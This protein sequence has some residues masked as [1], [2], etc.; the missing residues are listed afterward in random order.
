MEQGA[1]E[2]CVAALGWGMARYAR[3]SDA[4]HAPGTPIR[5]RRGE[6]D[7]EGEGWSP[8]PKVV[9]SDGDGNRT[10]HVPCWPPSLGKKAHR[11]NPSRVGNHEKTR[12]HQGHRAWCGR[13]CHA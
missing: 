11:H 1:I 4:C 7:V 3:V 9:G 10:T 8:K 2:A 6:R 5:H 13:C 12:F